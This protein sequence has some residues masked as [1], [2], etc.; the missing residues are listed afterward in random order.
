MPEGTIHSY[1][2]EEQ[3]GY[4]T[5]QEGGENVLFTLDA[6][7][8]RHTGEQ[9]AAGDPVTYEFGQSDDRPRAVSIHRSTPRG[10][11]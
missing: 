11:G 5:P 10:Y 8:D 6:V 3:K 9:P 4:I 7:K 2:P 1:D